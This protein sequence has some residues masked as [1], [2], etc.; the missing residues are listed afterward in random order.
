[1]EKSLV[2]KMLHPDYRG[3]LRWAIFGIAVLFVVTSLINIVGS[4]NVVA[5]KLD[6]ALKATPVVKSLPIWPTIEARQS[7]GKK[8]LKFKEI[9]DI[10]L[11]TYGPKFRLGLDLL[12]GTHLIYSADVSQVASADRANAVNGVRDVI[13]RRVNAFGVAEPLVQTNQTENDWRIIV[14][15]AGVYNVNDA[16]KMIG[17]TPLLEFK[18]ED[19]APVVAKP[20]TTEQQK[21]VDNYNIEA[22]NRAQEALTQV[23]AG[24]DMATLAKERSDDTGSKDNGGLYQGVTKGTFVPAFDDVVFNK[25]KVGETYKQLVQTEFGYHIIRKEAQ[26]TSTVD[27]RHI[28]I[29]TMSAADFNQNTDGNWKNTKLT[30]KQL[31]RA[32]VSYDSTSM[33]PEV[34]LQFDEEGAKLFAELTQKNVGKRLAIFLDGSPISTPRVNTPILEGNAVISGK[35]SLDEAKQLAQRLNAGALPVPIN[36]ISQTT[37][38]ASLG[39]D[40]I[41]KSVNAA[42]WGILLVALFMILYYRLPGLLS[43][44]A[45]GVYVTVVLTIFK[46]VPVTLTLSGIAGFVLSIGIAVDANVLIFERIKEELRA[47]KDLTTAIL[48]GFKR[49][50]TSIRDSNFSSLI[51]S[52]ILFWFGS[53]IIRGF[54]L[55]LTIGII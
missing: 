29:R 28:L 26:G 13:E 31:K 7:D 2:Q 55:T 50:W 51:T 38:G 5:R 16:I 8:T 15:L 45:L 44:L 30:G 12:G 22:K 21:I 9:T 49:A 39:N 1:M 43:V 19:S 41:A 48:D 47:G 20:L 35:F 53:G 33:T 42:L 18:E 52:V 37:V 25:L 46:M 36:L 54:A 40:S 3:K 11:T 24:S 6:S 4:D 17:A 23:L 27:V 34:S 14:E 10:N 32:D